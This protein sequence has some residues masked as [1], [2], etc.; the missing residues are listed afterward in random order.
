MSFP[1]PG[2]H[3]GVS[4]AD[5]HAVGHAQGVVS[6]SLLWKFAA[7]PFVWKYG[8]PQKVTEAMD[9]GSLVDCLAL[10]PERLDEDFVVSPY[11]EI[12]TNEAKAWRA[13]QT[14]TVIKQAEMARAI[15]AACGI[16]NNPFAS[17]F[18]NG[19]DTQVSIVC[20]GVDVE[21]ARPFRAK[22]RLDIVPRNSDWL[23]D[24]KTTGKDLSKIPSIIDDFGYHV[25]A[26]FYLD[27]YNLVTGEHRDRW[28]FIFQSD[29]EPFEVAVAE[30]DPKDIEAGRA[31]YQNALALWCRCERDQNWPSPW[32]DG[33][34][35]VSR[36]AWARK[37]DEE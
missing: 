13:S 5:Y 9:W 3:Y 29:T 22:C 27:L 37:G 34:K 26:A 24:L 35:M 33:I 21:T 32:E 16:V 31:W 17:D 18:L 25:Q 1:Q 19:A 20:D 30:L 28:A 8:P 6:K 23:V 36:P 12:R 15:L 11:D 4:E 2:I 7:N 10:N 14:K